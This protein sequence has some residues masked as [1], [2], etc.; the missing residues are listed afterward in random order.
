M[1]HTNTRNIREVQYNSFKTSTKGNRKVT[2]AFRG[3]TLPVQS[4]KFVPITVYQVGRRINVGTF[5]SFSTD[6]NVSWTVFSGVTN[7][8]EGKISTMFIIPQGKLKEGSQ[9]MSLVLLEAKTKS[10]LQASLR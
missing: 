10:L 5:I 4:N 7:P 3:L 8:E 6:P 1:V 2:R 9:S